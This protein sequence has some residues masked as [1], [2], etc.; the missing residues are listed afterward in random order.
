MR[1][2]CHCVD[3]WG[4]VSVTAAVQADKA[5][6]ALTARACSPASQYALAVALRAKAVMLRWRSSADYPTAVEA[7]KEGLKTCLAWSTADTSA[8]VE[9][10]LHNIE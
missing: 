8:R 7:H 10:M 1:V 3:A 5:I 9:H 2:Y 4:L 6:T